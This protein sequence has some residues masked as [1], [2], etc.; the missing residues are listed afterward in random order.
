MRKNLDLCVCVCNFTTRIYTFC[1][2][3]K[4]RKMCENGQNYND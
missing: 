3:C 1:E 2:M 4:I